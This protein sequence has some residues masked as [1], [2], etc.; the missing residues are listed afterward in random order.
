MINTIMSGAEEEVINAIRRHMDRFGSNP[1][2]WY[3]GIAEN[4]R[5]KLFEDHQVSEQNGKWIYRALE[6]NAD[7]MEIKKHLVALGLKGDNNDDENGNI[8]FAFEK[9]DLGN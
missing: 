2:T 8:I 6:S 5:K 7:A 4:I 9:P 3:V 1:N